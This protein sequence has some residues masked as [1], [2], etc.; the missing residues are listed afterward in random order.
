MDQDLGK[1]WK[2]AAPAAPPPKAAPTI[3]TQPAMT[4]QEADATRRALEYK[5]VDHDPD[6]DP[7][8]DEPVPHHEADVPGLEKLGGSPP[9]PAKPPQP[10]QPT[11]AEMAGEAMSRAHETEPKFTAPV[12]GAEQAI[13]GGWKLIK[14][15][16]KL[17]LPQMAEGATDVIE[18]GLK[19]ALPLMPAAAVEAPIAT[20]A[21][22]ALGTGAGVGVRKGLEAAGA[23]KEYAGLGGAVAA[24]LAGGKPGMKALGK[25]YE[26]AGSPEVKVGGSFPEQKP[27]DQMS[28]EELVAHAN[29]I[30]ASRPKNFAWQRGEIA[31]EAAKRQAARSVPGPE[32][33]P[34]AAPEKT[35][36]GNGWTVATP[37]DSAIQGGDITAVAP[38]PK[39][40]IAPAAAAPT[41]AEVTPA[42][43][44]SRPAEALPPEDP[45]S[46]ARSEIAAGNTVS[47]SSL[48]RK[49][50]LGYGAATKVLEGAQPASDAAPSEAASPG[51]RPPAQAAADRAP[52]WVGNIPTSEIQVDAPRFQ[53]KA[54]VGQGGAGEE[55][56]GVTKWDPEKAGI[57]AVWRDPEDGKTYIVNGHHRMELAQRLNVPEM[58]VRYLTAGNAQEARLKGALINIAEGRGESTDAA[59]VFRDSQMTPAQ[60]AA[61]GVS[62]KGKVA[63]EGLALSNLSQPIFQDVIDGSLTTARG[64]ILGGVPN[65][66]DQAAL[67]DV[68]KQRERGGKRLTDETLRELIRMN[69]RTSTKTESS[70]DAGQFSMFGPEEI[71][72]SLLP[73]KAEISGYVRRQLLAEKK[74]FGVVST[75]AAAEKL[76]ESG[77]V[78]KAGENAQVAERANQGSALYDKLSTMAGPIDDILDRAA[79]EIADGQS[80]NDAKQRA[81]R[82]VRD[83][84]AEQLRT[85]TGTPA[86]KPG[87]GGGTE[88]LGSG[89]ARDAGSGERNP[90]AAEVAPTNPLKAAAAKRKAAEDK[91]RDTQRG[92][93][94]FKPSPAIP[95]RDK[96][97][98]LFSDAEEKQ[99]R[100][101]TAS[102]EARLLGDRLTAQ[103]KSGLAAKPSKLKPA[104]NRGLFDESK[105]ETGS[106]FDFGSERGSFS[107]KP[108]PIEQAGPDYKKSDS[109]AASAAKFFRPVESRIRE[110]GPAGKELARKLN[111][112]TDIG[113]VSAGKRVVKLRDAGLHDLSR[114]DRQNLVDSL[115]GLAA[116]RNADVQKALDAVRE[117]TDE[118]AAEA[119]ASGVKVKVKQT[120]RP[121]DPLPAGARLTKSQDEQAAMGHNVAITY[122]R[123]FRGRQNF[124]PHIIPSPDTLQYGDARKDVIANMVRNGVQPNAKAAAQMIDEYRKFMDE[125]GRAKSLEKYLVDSGQARDAAEAYLLMQR[126]RKRTIR[127]QG[128]LE[129]ARQADFPF[130]DPDPGRVLP[131]FVTASSMR[132]AQIREFGQNNEQV[133]RLV[134]IINDTGGDERFVRAAVDRALQMTQQPDTAEARI[135]RVVRMLNGFKLGM[136]FIPNATQGALNSFLKSDLP[137]TIAG[138]KGLLTKEG[139]R[140]AMQSGAS[141]EGVI[142]EMLRSVGAESGPL[143]TFLKAT[144]F[145]PTEQANRVWA[146]NA[147]FAYAK[148]ML[149]R[150]QKNP[151]D[152]RARAVLEE[153]G[154]KPDVLL[155]IGKLDGDA[156]LIAAKKFSDATQFRGGVKDLP[157]FA[158]T[159]MG[160]VIFQFKSFVY[161]QTRLV[162]REL[163]GELEAGR[164][165]RA[166]RTLLI[167]ATVFPLAGEAIAD[168]RSWLKGGERKSEGLKRYFEDVGQA[169]SL[170]VAYDLLTSGAY[171]KGVNFL[172]GPTLSDVGDVLNAAG[173]GK[174]A[175]ARMRNLGKFAFR[176]IP[177]MGPMLYDR[178][179]PPKEKKTDL[180]LG[181]RGRK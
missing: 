123:P 117:V 104:E 36:L 181:G 29:E 81:Y 119:S 80:T 179:F 103:I 10:H 150:L 74:L 139:R 107:T 54:N 149:A 105:P 6:W 158:S 23:R 143:G 129:Y 155:K 160:K 68:M 70:E 128:S 108:V 90:P 106:L 43:A 71:T 95:L 20:A 175:D 32:T 169:G 25:L 125:G 92:S 120:L 59:R 115:Q 30:D 111:R 112:A 98:P 53:F 14:A 34:P 83:H 99:S 85:L 21:T 124:Y 140:F 84:L 136:S 67:Y 18:G 130:Y 46:W 178:V 142:N 82:G 144:G 1:G 88:V 64:A 152:G 116:P 118:L 19:V 66:A 33:S 55:L 126:F 45:L 42:P 113:E 16:P 78:I 102:G 163:I 62:L 86:V 121:G 131:Q 75:Q 24:V 177:F 49:F 161:G 148:R 35:D 174:D 173:Q 3:P 101:A 145:G 167:L 79:K 44:S 122:S 48:Q 57:T 93:F 26:A 141:L 89:G 147:G 156:A 94:S 151:L 63:S 7:M 137:S 97:Q 77:N 9:P 171:G 100:D 135:S 127:R 164:P 132:L 2:L 47:V 65:H 133:N 114:D 159:P 96:N 12:E 91:L 15:T 22:L 50:Q 11:V 40:A 52:G 170:G 27:F 61:D 168:V 172:A 72:R 39:R 134:K 38:R 166:F 37:Q 162:Y 146:A 51:T 73:E 28:D 165:G 176:H 157:L 60:L 56:R 8:S 153:L 41:P 180:R 13:G 58:T 17:D 4:P 110:Q 109:L 154:L 87:G 5:F 76:G 69:E 31:K 138:G